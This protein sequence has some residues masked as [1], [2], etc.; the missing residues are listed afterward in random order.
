MSKA[1]CLNKHSS[2]NIVINCKWA[3]RVKPFDP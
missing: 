2:S 3:I 1:V